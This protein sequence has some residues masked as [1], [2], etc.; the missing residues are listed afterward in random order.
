ME[1]VISEKVPTICLNMI[2]KN[3]SKIILRILK[4]VLPIID[5]YCICDTGSTDNTVELIENFFNEH[6]I[7]GKVVITNFINFEHNRNQALKE[8]R[9]M[10]D[11]LLLL[12]A[13]MILEI[14]NFEKEMLL[15]YDGFHLL[16]G[17]PDFYY[18][19][20][21]II[22]NDDRFKYVG[23]THEYLSFPDGSKLATLDKNI[24]FINDCG[25]GGCKSDKFER[26]IRLLS[27]AIENDPKNERYHFYLANS[28]HDLGKY[29]NAIQYYK[30]R[31]E[32]GGWIQEQWFSSF[33]IGLCYKH[34]G[35][36]EKAI[37]YWLQCHDIFPKRVENLY[38][39][40]NHYRHTSK[41]KLALIFYKVAKDIVKNLSESEKTDFLFLHND[42]YVYKLDYEYSIIAYYLGIKNIDSEMINVLNN[43]NDN[44]IVNNLINNIKFYKTILKQKEVKDFSN[45]ITYNIDD[46]LTTFNSSSSCLIQNPN[47]K[48]YIMNVRYVNYYINRNGHYSNCDKYIT[49]L[50]KYVKLSE[51]FN[52]IEE[53][54]FELNNDKRRYLGIEDIKI[55][56]NKE[57]NNIIFIGTT[58]HN[59]G[60]LGLSNGIY[61]IEN[62]MLETKELSTAF[63]RKDC[64]KNWTYVCVNNELYIIYEWKPLKICKLN[65]SNNQ[66]SIVQTNNKIPNIFKHCRGSSCGFNY[67]NEL[68]FVV[69]LVEYST[70]RIYYH[71]IVVLD[72]SF[73]I[74]KYSAPFKFEDEPIEYCL[75]LVVNND[76]VIINYSCWDRT[77]KIGIYEKK[78]IDS[79]LLYS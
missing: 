50:N 58:L 66:I 19:N 16:Q 26:D 24:L 31:I 34:L 11:Y 28:Y 36:V 7:S 15:D 76:D 6:S 37:Y 57:D 70:P 1:L 20:L 33:R 42:V 13:D 53:K 8:A 30:K 71:M 12:D 9:G 56:H 23:V 78:Y 14:Y 27:K 54:L 79:L 44:S 48:G 67:N 59:S 22:K 17:S 73:N 41:H 77:T 49:T 63:S 3:E 69:H 5:T 2:V 10:S 39:I 68:W 32:L 18:K 72:T 46:E 64:E 4:S 51:D 40:I 45:K 75:S 25:D 65:K 60:Q 55:F 21:R 74:I 62:S 47:E 35:D 61:N 38:E 52:I 29:I 43:S